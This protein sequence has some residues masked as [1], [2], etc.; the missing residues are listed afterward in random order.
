MDIQTW[1]YDD[2]ADA[3]ARYVDPYVTF[4]S[5]ILEWGGMKFVIIRV[6]EFDSIPVL[7]KKD[8]QG[9]LREGACYVRTR[10]KPETAEIA[11]QTE[12]REL[13]D[14][15]TTKGIRR[16]MTQAHLSGIT[17]LSQPPV[18]NED[19]FDDQ[20]DDLLR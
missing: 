12:M 20:I 1:N 18:T 10:R 13:L 16:V 5:A 19:L 17:T 8:Y 14:L 3:L 11:N 6:Q 4:D 2:F 9:I 7:C 15:A